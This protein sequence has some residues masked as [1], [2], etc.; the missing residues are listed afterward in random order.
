MINQCWWNAENPIEELNNKVT[1]WHNGDS[2]KPLHKYL[3][4]YKAQYRNYV[5]NGIIELSGC[6]VHCPHTLNTCRLHSWEC[7]ECHNGKIIKE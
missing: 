6:Q 1:E 7:S 3:G 2:D 4:L 5:E